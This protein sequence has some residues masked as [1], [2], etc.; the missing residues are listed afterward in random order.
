MN[1]SK[2]FLCKGPGDMPEYSITDLNVGLSKWSGIFPPVFLQWTLC[3]K[4]F[5]STH[6]TTE[7]D[8]SQWAVPSSANHIVF[9][10]HCYVGAVSELF[11]AINLYYV[12]VCI[13]EPSISAVCPLSSP[14]LCFVYFHG[15]LCG[16]CPVAC[17][18]W[19]DTVCMKIIQGEKQIKW[20]T[21]S[22]QQVGDRT[23]LHS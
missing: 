1:K 3:F 7:C 17:L 9:Q 2:K 18:H 13:C 10:L 4:W 8:L 6:F 23:P 5:A 21:A 11:W 16:L 19:Y 14:I 20:S 22:K 12:E 15:W